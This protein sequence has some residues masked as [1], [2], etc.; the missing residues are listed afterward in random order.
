MFEKQMYEMIRAR[1]ANGY[2]EECIWYF[3]GQDTIKVGVREVGSGTM[4][5]IDVAR[6]RD[7]WRTLVSTVINTAKFLSSY[8]TG[9]FSRRAQL[10][11]VSG[12]GW[13]FQKYVK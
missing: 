7:Q 8:T 4:N 3:G 10:Q 1:S 13:I 12:N 11:E 6:D 2:E 5:R 9:D